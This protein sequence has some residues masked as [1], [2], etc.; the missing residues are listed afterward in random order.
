MSA[1][2][3]PTCGAELRAEGSCRICLLGLAWTDEE[4]SEEAAGGAWR[5]PG[6]CEMLE[7]IGRG[8]AGVVYRA[9][10]RGANR[11]VALKML[12]PLHLLDARAR[13]RFEDEIRVTA[14]LEHPHIL[15]VHDI[16]DHD[17]QPFYT[18]KLARGGTLQDRLRAGP[19]EPRAAA[20]LLAKIAQAVHFAHQHGILHRDIKP[21]NILLDSSDSPYMADF[22]VAR[23]FDPDASAGASATRVGTPSYMSPEQVLG[24]AA[25]AAS[26]VYSLGSVLYEMVSGNPPFGGR[27]TRELLNRVVTE[28][29]P[30]LPASVPPQLATLCLRALAKEPVDRP[31][32]A[33]S[34]A[35]ELIAFH[36]GRRADP[37]LPR[38]I[39]S[40][41]VVGTAALLALA[42]LLG[43]IIHAR[44]Q[45]TAEIAAA[46]AGSAELRREALLAVAQ[47]RL[48]SGAVG[49][50]IVSVRELAE[51]AAGRPDPALRDAM[52][53]ALAQ[54]DAERVRE[55]RPPGAAATGPAAISA[56]LTHVALEES[57]GL[58]VLARRNDGAII[59]RFAHLPE[60]VRV[61]SISEFAPGALR[62]AARGTDG[63]L[64][65]WDAMQEAPLWEAPSRGREAIAVSPDGTRIASPP[66]EGGI[67]IRE[68]TSGRELARLA[69][70]FA[71]GRIAFSPDGTQIAAGSRREGEV[72]I[73]TWADQTEVRRFSQTGVESLAWSPDGSVL[74]IG[75]AEGSIQRWSPHTGIRLG[76]WPGHRAAPRR[77]AFSTD[78]TLL[79]SRAEDGVRIWRESVPTVRLTF[80]ETG[81]A[82][83]LRFAP[84]GSALVAGND[85][86]RL[87]ESEVRR[88]LHVSTPGG[89]A[90]PA[91]R[92]DLSRD[93][94]LLA[95]SESGNVVLLDAANGR[96]LAKLPGPA[97]SALDAAAGSVVFTAEGDTLLASSS[98]GTLRWSLRQTEPGAYELRRS[99]RLVAPVGFF[100]RHATARTMVFTGDRDGQLLLLRPGGDAPPLEVDAGDG[101][102]D[103]VLSPAGDLLL[104][105]SRDAPVRLWR[106]VEGPGVRRLAFSATEAAAFGPETDL[107]VLCDAGTVHFLR[108]P[109][110]SELG[111]VPARMR[112]VALSPDGALLAGAL[113]GGGVMLI[114]VATRE[115]LAVLPSARAD[116][117]RF[118]P[119]AESLFVLEGSSLCEWNL[120]RARQLL[121]PGLAWES[122][123][124][125]APRPPPPARSVVVLEP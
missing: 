73:Y 113:E 9:R 6:G 119:D 70:D 72:R 118:S 50:R 69:S 19:M 5:S 67:V 77:L 97:G 33:Q 96:M 85:E 123:A 51:A 11:E 104:T 120:T 76:S 52:L 124:S 108:W 109:E 64:R 63:I 110:C 34:F 36:E 65:A 121:P 14:A 39:L 45:A 25:T 15:P 13:Q 22:G 107:L 93:G 66:V 41:L 56:D 16:G 27:N 81:L 38:P 30:P 74:A 87:L 114:R 125:V 111:V 80:P 54:P 1:P 58:I 99:E 82:G 20:E 122:A 106:A 44:N 102:T 78:G 105:T 24:R 84:D 18:M 101:T 91:G 12:H 49:Q 90:D 79:V 29:P 100:V 68:F 55:V 115:I 53:A 32:S 75:T 116:A 92:F 83:P 28:S 2:A 7:E 21:G 88:E 71:V 95:L 98:A 47:L 117:L 61:E 89:A 31:A 17:G 60:G 35:E 10:Q 37:I 8:G 42:L 23:L 94:A 103:L 112:R 46:K 59:R 86:W 40:P 26:D 3:C 62:F 4:E 48:R 43:W 57:P